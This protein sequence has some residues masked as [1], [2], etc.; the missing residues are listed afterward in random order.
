V[1]QGAVGGLCRWCLWRH[2]T[3]WPPQLCRG[4]RE[5]QAGC[6]GPGGKRTRNEKKKCPR[7]LVAGPGMEITRRA[8]GWSGKNPHLD[9]ASLHPGGCPP[10]QFI[11]GNVRPS[12]SP[13]WAGRGGKENIYAPAAPE[14]SRSTA[15]R[16]FGFAP[17]RRPGIGVTRGQQPGNTTHR[18][19]TAGARSTRTSRERSKSPRHPHAQRTPASHRRKGAD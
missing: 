12:G 3:C 15:S 7:S 14:K 6:P 17:Y 4:E 18:E 1:T 8:A 5:A 11:A 19:K 9:V 16:L 2:G 13:G 10:W